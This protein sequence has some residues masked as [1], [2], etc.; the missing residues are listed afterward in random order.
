MAVSWN[1]LDSTSKGMY[2]NGTTQVHYKTPADTILMSKDNRVVTFT[3]QLRPW[4]VIHYYYFLF[5]LV[6][7]FLP[8]FIYFFLFESQLTSHSRPQPHLMQ[9]PR[10][11]PT[12]FQPVFSDGWSP[13]IT[14]AELMGFVSPDHEEETIPLAS[15]RE[16]RPT[17]SHRRIST[18]DDSDADELIHG[19]HNHHSP[20]T[21][22]NG[23]SSSNSSSGNNNPHNNSSHHANGHSHNG[24]SRRFGQ[25]SSPS[26]IESDSLGRD[27]PSGNPGEIEQVEWLS[28]LQSSGAKI[29]KVLF[30]RIANNDKE[31]TVVRLVN[32]TTL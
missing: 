1:K 21:R 22:H 27:S 17:S 20:I 18:Y 28:E 19:H 25:S 10:V 2:T 7:L 31:L 30:P 3:A 11:L 23:K 8:P 13:I 24:S 32:I 9:S 4:S 16:E 5:F 29:V 12:T 14:E 15:L 6:S 26:P